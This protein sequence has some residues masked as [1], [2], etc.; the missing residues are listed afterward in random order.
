M[1]ADD[2]DHE[3]LEVLHLRELAEAEQLN[4]RDDERSDENE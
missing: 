3:L 1:S 4:E 2:S